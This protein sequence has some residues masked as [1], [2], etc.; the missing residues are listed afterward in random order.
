MWLFQVT[1]VALLLEPPPGRVAV[2]RAAVV[3]EEVRQARQEDL[4]ER[5]A[6]AVVAV[7]AAADP[8][9]VGH[10]GDRLALVEL[11]VAGQPQHA[12][13]SCC[14]SYSSAGDVVA[15]HAQVA[16]DAGPTATAAPGASASGAAGCPSRPRRGSA[17]CTRSPRSGRSAGASGSRPRCRSPTPSPRSG[18]RR[19]ARAAD[20]LGLAVR[21]HAH[22]RAPRPR[23]GSW[24]SRVFFAPKTQPVWHHF[25]STQRL[26]VDRQ[27]HAVARVA[28][29]VQRRRPQPA[30]LRHLVPRRPLHAQRRARR[31]RST[32]SSVLREISLRP[33]APVRRRRR[34]GG[35]G[36]RR[37]RAAPAATRPGRGS[38]RR[39]R[40]S[41]SRPARRSGRAR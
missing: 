2:G 19:G 29:G 32:G 22:A 5:E 4:L 37:S 13:G 27:R 8:E 35:R 36:A 40:R 30:G 12:A 17:P 33:H 16:P 31:A 41:R 18:S 6:R 21:P 11:A 24:C 28:G 23:P 10:R 14:G 25:A 26:A 20:R 39:P 7:A 3:V 9:V 38:S 34:R 1:I 15:V